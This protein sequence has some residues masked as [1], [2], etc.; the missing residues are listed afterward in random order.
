MNELYK[1]D[2]WRFY[3]NF[4]LPSAKLIEKKRIASKTV[5]RYDKPKTPFQRV[6]ESPDIEQSAER[7]LKEQYE[8][9]NPFKFR[10][11]IEAKLKQ[12]FTL[13]YPKTF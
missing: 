1:S 4:F 6:L 9:A 5:K 13:C 8:A 12:I 11:E 10:K 2:A 7:A 3:H